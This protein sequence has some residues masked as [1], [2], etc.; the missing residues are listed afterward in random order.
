VG[1]GEGKVRRLAKGELD[2]VLVQAREEQWTE[3]ALVWEG[4]DDIAQELVARG[5]SPDR[6]FGTNQQIAAEEARALAS[7]TRL[8]SLHISNASGSHGIGDEGTRA[9]AS[10]E[11]LTSL[12]LRNNEIG[13]E[14]ARALALLTSLTSLHV[15]SN[16]GGKGIGAEGARALAALTSLVSL[17]L[18]SHE[19]GAEGARA[20]AALTSLTSLDL[21]GNKIGDEGA[22]ALAA[23]TSLTS[24]D[25]GGN[26]IGDEGARALASLTSLTFLNLGDNEIG[27]EGARALASLT[28]LTY[29]DLSPTWGGEGIGDEGARALMSLTSLTSLILHTSR[30]GD[31]GARALASLA[32]LTVLRLG[33]NEIGDEGAR[34]LGSL[35]S[36]LSLDLSNNAITQLRSLASLPRLEVLHAFGNPVAGIPQ[37]L[38]RAEYDNSLPALTAYFHE[39]DKGSEPNDVVKILLV[40]NGCVG[41]T[42]LAYSLAHGHAP[43][44]PIEERT[45]GIVLQRVPLELPSGARVDAHLWDFGGQE[46]Y[47]ATHRLFFHG[48]AIYLLLWA[49]ES[50]EVPEEARHPVSYW[51]DMIRHLAADAPVLLVKNQI[52][53]SNKRGGPPELEGR[54]LGDVIPVAISAT[55]YRNIAGLK[56]SLAEVVEGARHRWGYLLPKSWQEVRA[57]LEAWR[58]SGSDGAGT[59]LRMIPRGRFEQLCIKHGIE[60][61][62]VLL[63]FLHDTGELFH[64]P[65]RFRDV[66]ILDQNWFIDAIY[67]LFDRKSGNHVRALE[68]GGVLSGADSM[69]YWPEQSPE[70]RATYFDFMLQARMAFE[71]DRHNYKPFEE[72][73]I[74]VPALLPSADAPSVQLLLEQWDE[75][76]DGESWL[77]I[78][79]PFL[80][81]GHIERI[82]VE[83][84]GL[85]QERCWWWREGILARD[86][87]TDCRLLVQLADQQRHIDIRLRRGRHGDGFARLMGLL[88]RILQRPPTRILASMDGKTFVD[89]SSVEKARRTG[90]DHVPTADD[91]ASIL[92]APFD[93]FVERPASLQE[94]PTDGPTAKPICIFISHSHHE[95]DRLFLDQ[96]EVRLEAIKRLIPID[97]WHDRMLLAGTH[98]SEAIYAQLAVADVVLLLVSPEF[99][100]SEQGFSVEMVEALKKY[101]NGRGIPVPILI[102][103]ENT[104][105]QHQIGQLQALPKN[106][107]AISMWQQKEDEAWLDV[108]DGL[109]ALLTDLAQRR[110]L[111]RRP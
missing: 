31:E 70:D 22:R 89:L 95:R 77:R 81:R 15:S 19:I 101:E 52:D 92:R 87:Q 39:L 98:T 51:L 73:R 37:E 72:R 43:P 108:A 26:E 11:S 83:L 4:Y 105:R 69:L 66:I 48:K 110:G 46:L 8:T 61:S 1:I 106:G 7:L 21:G 44:A 6:V 109:Q 96:L 90:R 82:I 25:L 14:G 104:W 56:A 68:H 38:L 86:P 111:L 94:I 71:L 59:P 5:W 79:C 36:L 23:L 27:A 62:N 2:E 57:T 35:A 85:S 16:F 55:K 75:P 74:V 76:V 13:A 12:H 30:I 93:R 10:I 60:D 3:L 97:P 54:E 107:P 34:A 80:H 18:G 17:D 24:L 53:R 78:E 45:H 28:S 33:G 29:L 88:H 20:L 65:G 100:A 103:P 32:N 67:R 64:R 102:R 47:H 58:T 40:G 42:T 99:M 84:S 41:K 49:E 9:L 91:G 63:T 50:D